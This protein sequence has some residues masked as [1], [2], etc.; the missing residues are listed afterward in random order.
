[1]KTMNDFYTQLAGTSGEA[2]TLNRRLSALS[3]FDKARIAQAASE[4]PWYFWE[5][6]QPAPT[7]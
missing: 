1:M 5:S 7:E 4:A 6:P 3:K 2:P